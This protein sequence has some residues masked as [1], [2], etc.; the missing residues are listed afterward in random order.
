[1][2]QQMRCIINKES[3]HKALG[4]VLRKGSCLCTMAE[5]TIKLA[6][7]VTGDGRL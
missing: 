2:Q 4:E 5:T 7:P 1:M 3:L 6:F